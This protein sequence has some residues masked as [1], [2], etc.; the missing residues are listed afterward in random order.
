MAIAITEPIKALIADTL[1]GLSLFAISAFIFQ[2][3]TQ[4]SNKF[5]Y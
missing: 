3:F 5:L 2:T 1:W 4:I